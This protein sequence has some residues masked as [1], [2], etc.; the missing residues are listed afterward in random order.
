MK[1]QLVEHRCFIQDFHLCKVTDLLDRFCSILMMDQSSRP[2][3]YHSYLVHLSLILDVF[4]HSLRLP[5][6]SYYWVSLIPNLFQYVV[7]SVKHLN[8][9]SSREDSSSSNRTKFGSQN[10]GIPCVFYATAVAGKA[11]GGKRRR[12]S[13]RSIQG[14][15]IAWRLSEYDEGKIIMMDFLALS[16]L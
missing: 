8:L 4:S 12:H 15:T 1:K 11:R 2:A 7:R 5:S 9:R 13:Q 14:S 3:L 16:Y 6:L 10:H